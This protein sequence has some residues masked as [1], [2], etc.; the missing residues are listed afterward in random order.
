[1]ILSHASGEDLRAAIQ[2]C[3]TTT[4]FQSLSFTTACPLRIAAQNT[5]RWQPLVR[6]GLTRPHTCDNI[7]RLAAASPTSPDV[8]ALAPARGASEAP[9]KYVSGGKKYINRRA[10]A[11]Q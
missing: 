1:M 11:P 3:P 6:T 9:Q 4:F 5:P 2:L 7:A 8:A 10:S